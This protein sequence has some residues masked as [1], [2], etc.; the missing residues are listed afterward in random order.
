MI[1]CPGRASNSERRRDPG[2]TRRTT[3]IGRA[4]VSPW[5]RL[6]L[7]R[8]IVHARNGRALAWPGHELATIARLSSQLDVRLAHHPAPLVH[9]GRDENAEFVWR[10]LARF[11]VELGEARD[12]VGLLQ[13]R[14]QAGVEPGVDLRSGSGRS[15]H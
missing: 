7:A 13:H 5:S 3:S 15:E 10:V 11:D 6:A 12:D 9:L 8:S 4:A 1:S 14:I 2:A